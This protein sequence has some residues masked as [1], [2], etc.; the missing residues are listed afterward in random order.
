MQALAT[1]I[2]TDLELFLKI[3]KKTEEL[4]APLEI[5]DYVVQA[6]FDASPAKWHLAHTTW[7]FENFILLEYKDNY[8]LYNEKFNLIFNSYYKSMGEHWFQGARGTLSRPTVKEVCAY[9]HAITEQVCEFLK[10]ADQKTLEKLMPVFVVGL[11]HEEQHQELLLTDIKA[12]LAIN[13][14]NP[15]YQEGLVSKQAVVKAEFIEIPEG[16]Y[17]LGA[18]QQDELASYDNF[19]FDNERPCHKTYLMPFKL[20]NRCVTNAEYIEF[21]N[22]AGYSNH[23][24]WLSDAWNLL[25]TEKWQAPLYWIQ[26]GKE[27]MNMTLAGL[28]PVNPDEPVTHISFYEADAYAKWAGKRLPSEAEWE[29]AAKLA[30]LDSEHSEANF[31]EKASYHPQIASEQDSNILKMPVNEQKFYDLLGNSWEWTYSA[32]LQYPGYKCPS[33][34]FGEYNAKFMNKQRVLKGGSCATPEKHFRLSYRN[35]F[36]PEKRWQF[37]GFR[38]AE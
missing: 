36:D 26:D 8:K 38:L 14:I 35:F 9:R 11:H 32:Y 1:R 10:E 25:Q 13:P 22:D 4:C 24:F 16:L 15:I 20:M 31:M 28:R 33:G 18:K 37:T 27:W 19:S 34:A 23:E 7:F 17:N 12:A 29:V 5:E 30:Q 2:D 3:R 21:I 6:C